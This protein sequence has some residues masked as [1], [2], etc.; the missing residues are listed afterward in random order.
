MDILITKQRDKA[1]IVGITD[2]G[3]NWLF[4]QCK[5]LTHNLHTI[6]RDL[7]EDFAQTCVEADLKVDI[8]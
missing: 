2:K 3:R 8:K 1:Y 6:H 4:E 5:P 7:A